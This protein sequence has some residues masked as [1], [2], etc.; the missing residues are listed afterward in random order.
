MDKVLKGRLTLPQPLGLPDMEV[1]Q[2]EIAD[3]LLDAL[4]TIAG[5]LSNDLMDNREVQ[6]WPILCIAESAIAEATSEE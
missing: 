4:R 6:S 2:A 1:V 5:L 3:R